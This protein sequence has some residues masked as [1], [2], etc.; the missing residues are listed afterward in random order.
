MIQH[1]LLRRVGVAAVAVA[2]LMLS[3]PSPLA[4]SGTTQ[5][6]AVLVQ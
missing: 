1:A 3:V 6:D 4:T 5:V 2:L